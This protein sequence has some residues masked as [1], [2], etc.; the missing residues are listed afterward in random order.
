MCKTSVRMEDDTAMLDTQET[1]QQKLVYITNLEKDLP[2]DGTE[3][4]D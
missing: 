2:N 1:N 3:M 4:N